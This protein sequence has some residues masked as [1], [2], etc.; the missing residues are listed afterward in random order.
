VLNVSVVMQDVGVDALAID[1][2]DDDERPYA[3]GAMFG[4]QT[5]GVALAIALSGWV[6]ANYNLAAAALVLTAIPV[7]SIAFG[8][9]I[10][11]REGER[12]LPWGQGEAHHINL[13]SHATNWREIFTKAFRALIVP[14]SL[15]LVPLLL[16][17]SIP[18]GVAGTYGPTLFT[19]NAQWSTSDF[20]NFVAIV[21]VGLALYTLLFSGKITQILGERRAFLIAVGGACIVS[22]AFAGLASLWAE[23]WFLVGFVLIT[24]LLAITALMAIIPICMRLCDHSVAGTQ[25]VIYMGITNLGSPIGAYL[26]TLTAGAGYDQL[27]FWILGAVFAAA[28]AWAIWAKRIFARGDNTTATPVPRG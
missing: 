18:G 26:T 22:C 5:L 1:L 27:L 13:A 2:F 24:E 25:F 14:G 11:E 19:Q 21:G 7:V 20:T 4:A 17:R 6:L 8:I 15:L 9:A 10:K 12:R 28:F 23:T 3:A 16:I